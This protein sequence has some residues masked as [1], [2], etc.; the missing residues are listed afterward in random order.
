M[1]RF[2]NR[3][4]NSD[5]GDESTLINPK[6]VSSN[7]ESKREPQSREQKLQNLPQYKE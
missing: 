7:E 1:S 3:K 4:D 5:E 6:K 2:A